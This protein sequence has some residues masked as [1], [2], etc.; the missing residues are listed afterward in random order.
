[1]D[2]SINETKQLVNVV[3]S[4]IYYTHGNVCFRRQFSV[5]GGNAGIMATPYLLSH[6][7]IELQ[8]ATNHI[9]H[10]LLT[11]LLLENMKD[12]SRKSNTEEGLSFFHQRATE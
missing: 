2:S 9:G 11:N 7:G 4:L 5:S 3:K 1:M 12:T 6:D 8:F 10:F